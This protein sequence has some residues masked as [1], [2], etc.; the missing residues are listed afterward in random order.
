MRRGRAV[1]IASRGPTLSLLP[2]ACF[3]VK[4]GAEEFGGE[5]VRERGLD[6]LVAALA[7]AAVEDG[8][9]L[10]EGVIR[11]QRLVEVHVVHIGPA[12]GVNVLLADLAIVDHLARMAPGLFPGE[13]IALGRRENEAETVV[14]RAAAEIG[15]HV[16]IQHQPGMAACA[17]AID[18]AVQGDTALEAGR[19]I[20]LDQLLQL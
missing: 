6:S 12:G 13:G 5:W 4:P 17:V 20:R 19:E 15:D 18:R 2:D 9:G 3:R 14:M 7:E 10:D 16:A 8:E 1:G 11:G